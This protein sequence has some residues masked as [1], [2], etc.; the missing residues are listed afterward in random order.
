MSVI[1]Q[2][3]LRDAWRELARYPAQNR[4]FQT[5][6]LSERLLIDAYAGLRAVD[7][8]PC[9]IID[10]SPSPD[11]SFE[12]GGMRLAM[13]R[14]ER[15]PLMVLSLEDQ[16]CL[17]LFTTVCG[18]ALEA[19]RTSD[20]DRGA[21]LAEFLARLNSWRRFL[22]ERRS[23]LSRLETIGLIGELLVLGELL[24]GLPDAL[25]DWK[26]PDDGLHDFERNGC[27]LEVK[28]SLGTASSVRIST[29]DQLDTA[30]LRGLDL[31]HVKLIEA[32]DGAS[33]QSIIVQ[34]R[35]LIG[36]D[37]GRRAFENALLR[38]GLMPDDAGA[39]TTPCVQLRIIDS[40]TVGP[41][42]P[43]LARTDVPQ[44]VT[45]AQ[46]VL[47]VRA[48]S[49]FSADTKAVLRHFSGGAGP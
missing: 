13:V 33:L 39:R 24:T 23:G 44:A 35:N 46:Y 14:G 34:I 6:R 7:A 49:A 5:R 2:D 32:P 42:F 15:G 43:R 10:A 22:R 36:S 31:L 16:T 11:P 19:S 37:S 26:A 9:L 4:E 8:A 38:R 18:D 20:T 27:A 48:L 21:A 25:T 1:W 17:D 41:D 29:L 47:D 45:D 30:G 40:Y 3:R 12:V 28:T